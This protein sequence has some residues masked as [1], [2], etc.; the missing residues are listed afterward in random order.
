MTPE[1]AWEA[2]RAIVDLMEFPEE[3]AS[4][5]EETA[6]YLVDL[7]DWIEKGGYIPERWENL[8]PNALKAIEEV[9]LLL[10]PHGPNDVEHWGAQLC[11]RIA[12]TLRFS[13]LLKRTDHE[14]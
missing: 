6:F 5:E 14:P 10:F 9:H 2:V 7:I 3:F 8:P 4:Q 1:A 12:D 13:G 11:Q